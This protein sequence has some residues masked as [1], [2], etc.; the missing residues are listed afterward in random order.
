MHIAPKYIHIHT[1]SEAD[2]AIAAYGPLKNAKQT[3]MQTHR[4]H[5]PQI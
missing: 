1:N 5:D 4:T 2:L 3:H